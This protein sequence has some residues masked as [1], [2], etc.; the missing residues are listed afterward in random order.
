MKKLFLLTI[1]FSLITL[2]C[3]KDPE[4][5]PE[6]TR[7][8][9]HMYHFV[10]GLEKI[11]WVVDDNEVPDSK[12]YAGEFKGSVELE[13]ATDE[14]N[15][16]V[17]HSETGAVL[18]SEFLVL[19]EDKY[20][21]VIATGTEDN[22]VLILHEIETTSPQSGQVKFET[23]H[24]IIDQGSIDVYMGGSASDKRVVSDLSYNS[25]SL[26]FEVT[27]ADARAAITVTAHSEEYSQ[28]SVLLTSV[29]NEDILSDANYLSVVASF[30]YDPDSDL[31]FW[32][33]ALPQD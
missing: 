15:F 17:K 32:L 21:A 8:Y 30:T 12:V 16:T 33:Y 6:E 4:T 24:S 31:T 28:D 3:E 22:P 13:T 20:Y 9:C 5:E 2:S 25:I 23:L 27:E 10:S 18:L 26:P 19:E 29:Y 1:L 14:I 11:L 7:A